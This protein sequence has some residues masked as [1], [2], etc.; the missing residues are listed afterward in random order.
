[1]NKNTAII[2]GIV[3]VLLIIGGVYAAMTNT[4][5]TMMDKKTMEA[6]EQGMQNTEMSDPVSMDKEE[7][8]IMDD[9]SMQKNEK[10]AMDSQETEPMST[11]SYEA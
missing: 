4:T 6:T 2:I 1:M 3:A 8:K 9:E 10:Q 5:D 7:D 11:G